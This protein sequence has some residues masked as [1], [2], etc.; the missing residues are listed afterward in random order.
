HAIR[1]RLL[2]EL[3]SDYAALR[4]T[5]ERLRIATDNVASLDAT[6]RLTEQSNRR[7][8]GTSVAVAQARAALQL[9]QAML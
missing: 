9:A 3:A 8:L 2:A 4:A 1:G 7:G 5:Q 6:R